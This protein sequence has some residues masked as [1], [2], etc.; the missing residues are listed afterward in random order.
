[1]ADIGEHRIDKT[2]AGPALV[3]K[4]GSAEYKPAGPADPTNIVYMEYTSG[5][6][7]KKFGDELGDIISEAYSRFNAAHEER[8]RLSKANVLPAVLEE[9]KRKEKEEFLRYKDELI[10]CTFLGTFRKKGGAA[11]AKKTFDSILFMYKERDRNY[12]KGL[13][14]DIAGKIG[15][16][17]DIVSDL[18]KAAE[19]EGTIVIS[20]E[21]AR[22]GAAAAGKDYSQDIFGEKPLAGGDKDKT[23]IM[24]DLSQAPPKE[25]KPTHIS[26]RAV[27][28]H[29]EQYEALLESHDK[30]KTPEEAPRARRGMPPA[31]SA[32]LSSK[33]PDISPPKQLDI[34]LG[35][36]ESEDAPIPVPDGLKVDVRAD[37]GKTPK[38]GTPEIKIPEKVHADQGTESVVPETPG[39][40]FPSEEE[41]YAAIEE[42]MKDAGEAPATSDLGC[43]PTNPL[44]PAVSADDI[45]LGI[46][47][48]G[49]IL[50]A[51]PGLE[52]KIEAVSAEP[53]AADDLVEADEEGRVSP[54][55]D[56]AREQLVETDKERG[57]RPVKYSSRRIS[58][59]RSKKSRLP[60]KEEEEE[61]KPK[62]GT[63]RK[64]TGRLLL[65]AAL[66]WGAAYGIDKYISV[67]LPEYVK[68]VIDA[69]VDLIEQGADWIR[70][71]F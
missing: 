25:E 36:T 46:D 62:V 49:N 43:R 15:Y 40:E 66:G 34:M 23:L 52:E 39:E 45:P 37:P 28:L 1:M 19:G 14:R 56:T 58:A 6:V 21:E 11:G 24:K 32:Y 20:G 55:K 65:L 70:S 17:G 48:E 57:A 53:E 68:P 18:E 27:A 50:P 12:F 2:D 29:P 22:K 67:Q 61:K 63:F 10:I 13:L 8:E 51:E 35:K 44:M 64:W 26:R 4:V 16:R 71:Y 42:V 33:G 30:D 31:T 60:K 5:E 54:V 38:K 69:P 7:R 41:L 59:K 9:A 47:E 3:A